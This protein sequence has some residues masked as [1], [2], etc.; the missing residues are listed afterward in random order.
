LIAAG[1]IAAIVGSTATAADDALAV[2]A[3]DAELL[4]LLL[5]QAA[6]APTHSSETGAA[7]QLFHLLIPELLLQNTQK[8]GRQDMAEMAFADEPLTPREQS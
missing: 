2:V 6:I 3:V 5:P 7:N 4:V 1:T 8:Q